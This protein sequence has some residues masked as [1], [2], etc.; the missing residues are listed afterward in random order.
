[1]KHIFFQNLFLVTYLSK[2]TQKLFKD[3]EGYIEK[4]S[5]LVFCYQMLQR[6]QGVG[7]LVQDSFGQ[8]WTV[9]GR[10]KPNFEHCPAQ[11]RTLAE[12]MVD[13]VSD[14]L[15]HISDDRNKVMKTFFNDKGWCDIQGT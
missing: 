6:E 13:D 15:D 7:L 12:S 9:K 4:A 3:F 5:N 10:F 2:T 1:M 11:N 8:F 14:K